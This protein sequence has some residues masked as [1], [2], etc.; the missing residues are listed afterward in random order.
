M[1]EYFNTCLICKRPKTRNTRQRCRSCKA[2]FQWATG[3]LGK[4]DRRGNKNPAWK[5]GKVMSNEGYILIHTPAHPRANHSGY[6]REH[7]LIWERTHEKPLPK[8][9]IVHHLNGIKNDNRP[10]NLTAFP[11]RKHYLVLEAKAKRIQEL[12]ALLA[13]Q[14]QLC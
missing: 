14:A 2:K 8:G 3:Q 12:E 9:C 13:H 1:A 5:G 7:I 4:W 11:N 10:Q 6:V